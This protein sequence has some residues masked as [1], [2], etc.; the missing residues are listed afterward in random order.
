MQATLRQST[1]RGGV[2]AAAAIAVAGALVVGPA[3]TPDA[4]IALLHT[5]AVELAVLPSWLQWVDDGTTALTAQIAAIAG[6]LQS[7]LDNPVPI[8]SAVLRNQVFNVQDV[9][10]ALITSAQVLASAAVSVPAL[11]L[12]A[13]FDA[14]S[15]PL[16]IPTILTALVADVIITAN[17]AVAPVTA[18]LSALATETFTRAVGVVNAVIANAA[19][20]A[21][22]VINVPVAIANAIGAAALGVA[23]SV[24]TLNP[25]NVVGAIGDGLVDIETTSFNAVAAVGTAVGNLREAVAAAVSFP[26]PPVAAASVP[27]AAQAV[28]PGGVKPAQRT[29][30]S[31]ARSAVPTELGKSAVP[32]ELGKSAV[33]VKKTAKTAKAA[34]ADSRR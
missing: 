34:A 15:N 13:V 20:I 4:S 11:L 6:G 22:A 24:L 31:A 1:V 30:K 33:P 17:A 5:D 2:C 25:L 23:G 16:S 7:E 19:P 27:K 21:G 26:L 3:P 12:N 28:S 9:G 10:G 14:V 29:A 32:T 8:V 18:A